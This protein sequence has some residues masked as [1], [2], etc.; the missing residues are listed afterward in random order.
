MN[1]TTVSIETAIISAFTKMQQ[2]GRRPASKLVVAQTGQTPYVCYDRRSARLHIAGVS[3]GA[4][5]EAFYEPF[6]K[7]LRQ[8]L[9]N[10]K[11]T[12]VELYLKDINPETAKVLFQLF[13]SLKKAMAEGTDSQ[14]FWMAD[15][16]NRKLQDMAMDFAELYELNLELKLI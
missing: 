10:K 5:M 3:L 15:R 2:L 8:G 13:K 14:V 12:T 6:V 7:E 4:G 16:S 1:T 9:T 11:A